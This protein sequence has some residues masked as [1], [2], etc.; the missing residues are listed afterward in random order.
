MKYSRN[1]ISLGATLILWSENHG[2]YSMYGIDFPRAFGLAFGKRPKEISV[3][4]WL[5]SIERGFA[6]AENNHFK[7]LIRGVPRAIDHVTNR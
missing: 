1:G 6:Q 4:K 3:G 7:P 5:R 2:K